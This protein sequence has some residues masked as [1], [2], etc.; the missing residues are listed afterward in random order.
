MIEEHNAQV[1]AA[2]VVP[3]EEVKRFYMERPGGKLDG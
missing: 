3:F 2:A 1:D